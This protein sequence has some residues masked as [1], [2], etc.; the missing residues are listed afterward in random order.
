MFIER[1][2]ELKKMN[3]VVHKKGMGTMLLYGRRRIGKSELAKQLLSECS[4]KHIY[5]EC[6]QVSEQS[7]VNSLA[8]LISEKNQE[9]LFNFEN[10]EQVLEYLFK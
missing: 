8:A 5:Y 10:I 2:K 9:P 1:S 7:N 6:K 4:C 3:K